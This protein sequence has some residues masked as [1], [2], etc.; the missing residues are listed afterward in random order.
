L[1][2]FFGGFW[3]CFLTGSH[4]VVMWPTPELGL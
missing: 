2:C 1:G 4:Y 3:G